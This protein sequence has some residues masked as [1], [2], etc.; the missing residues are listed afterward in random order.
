MFVVKVSGFLSELGP[1]VYPDNESI[2]YDADIWMQ[3]YRCG[4]VVSKVH[5]KHENE[6]T[7]I[8]DPPENIHDSQKVVLEVLH[9][10]SKAY[11]RKR[12]LIKRIDSIENSGAEKDKDLQLI[13]TKVN[14]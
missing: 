2:P 11:D 5:V 10:I 1:R 12:K 13:L 9:P 7:G 6:F 14:S 3:C 8:I 4:T